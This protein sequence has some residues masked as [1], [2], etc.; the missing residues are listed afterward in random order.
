[1]HSARVYIPQLMTHLIS[2]R[3]LHALL[4]HDT[5]IQDLGQHLCQEAAPQMLFGVDDSVGRD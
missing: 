2:L 5:R 3:R 4:D 1:M